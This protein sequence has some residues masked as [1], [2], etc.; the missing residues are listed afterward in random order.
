MCVYLIDDGVIG[1]ILLILVV[2]QVDYIGFDFISRENDNV[3]VCILFSLFQLLTRFYFSIWLVFGN[4]TV[5][6]VEII[7]SSLI[8][9]KRM[10]N[11]CECSYSNCLV[12]INFACHNKWKC[13]L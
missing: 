11:I 5:V 4:E 2:T 13:E 3:A 8:N 6:L 7:Y 12:V 9:F 1:F 10:M